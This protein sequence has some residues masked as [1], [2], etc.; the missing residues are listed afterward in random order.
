MA[1]VGRDDGS[2]QRMDAQLEDL[3]AGDRDAALLELTRLLDRF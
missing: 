1:A 2:P 3:H